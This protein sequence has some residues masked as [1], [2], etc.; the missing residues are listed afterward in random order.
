MTKFQLVGHKEH[1]GRPYKFCF[2]KHCTSSVWVT[3]QWCQPYEA[4][5]EPFYIYKLVPLASGQV[6]CVE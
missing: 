6:Y 2:D 1:R 3:T 4:E 5:G